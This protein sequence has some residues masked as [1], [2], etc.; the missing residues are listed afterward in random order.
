VDITQ[1]EFPVLCFGPKV[2]TIKN[3]PDD[4]LVSW[5]G[6][7]RRGWFAGLVI[8]DRI[9]VACRIKQ[10]VVVAKG[11]FSWMSLLLG[12]SVRIRLDQ[13]GEFFHVSTAQVRELVRASSI[14]WHGLESRPDFEELD[15]KME[16]VETIDEMI[17][18][19][20]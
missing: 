2:F 18:I 9:G 8:V 15:R 14:S 20:S 13:D 5:S 12:P 17:H 19:L 4:L 3:H 1:F 6:T 11:P 10:A 7:I 16:Q